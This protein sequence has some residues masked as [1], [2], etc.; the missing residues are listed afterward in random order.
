MTKKPWLPSLLAGMLWLAAA[1]AWAAP[2]EFFSF[3]D[4]VNEHG[5]WFQQNAAGDSATDQRR[6]DLVEIARDG[7]R[8]V[9]LTTLGYDVNVHSS[10]DSERSD[11]NLP[12]SASRIVEGAEQWWAHSFYLPDSF[13]M[14]PRA[15][16]FFW[17]VLFQFHELGGESRSQPPYIIEIVNDPRRGGPVLRLR[18]FD[19]H[20]PLGYAA[21]P[22]GNAA[23]KKNLWY[24]FVHYVKWSAGKDGVHKTWLRIGDGKR[25]ELVQE[26]RGP[27]LYAGGKG[28]AKLSNYHPQLGA[29]SSVIHDRV[30]LGSSPEEVAIPGVALEGLPQ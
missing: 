11:M 13:V 23:P 26:H 24:D 28:F 17:Y 8:G 2:A 5:R 27:T 15:R 12:D 29:P 19:S 20:P 14:P 6:I 9:R 16:P 22:L 21:Y 1:A 4:S 18:G 25:Y 10:G 7:R 30:V 3:E